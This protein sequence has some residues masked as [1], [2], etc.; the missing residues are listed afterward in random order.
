MG[1]AGRGAARA[2]CVALLDAGVAEI[3]IVNRTAA[4]AEALAA[5]LGRL[6]TV[7]RWPERDR[8][9]DGAR[10]L[11]NATSM[12]LA[13]Q[14]ALDLDL[15]GLPLDAVVAD[16]VYVP[17][18]TPLLAAAARRGHRVVDGLGIL[19]HQARPGFAAWFGV[20]PEVS[21]ELR[22]FMVDRL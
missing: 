3:R 18:E 17:L 15:A 4:R 9:L 22:A 8:A 2:V 11:V 19:L 7:K 13:G 5:G 10:L 1:R 12:G 16:L 14:P 20:E 21:A 6:C